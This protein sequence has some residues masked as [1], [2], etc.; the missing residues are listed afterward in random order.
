VLQVTGR[1]VVE[2]EYAVTFQQG[3]WSLD[4]ATLA[5][6]RDRAASRADRAALGDRSAEIIDFVR[7]RPGGEAP[8]ADITGKFGKDAANYLTR[9]VQAGRLIKRKRGLYAVPPITPSEVSEVSETQVSGDAET[10][11]LFREVSETGPAQGAEEEAP[12]DQT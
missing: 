6:A 1:D 8:A 4:G 9:H 5:E 12:H 3:A 2:A 11:T 7:K 10:H